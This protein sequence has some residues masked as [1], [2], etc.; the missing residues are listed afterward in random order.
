MNSAVCNAPC[1]I[2]DSG[3]FY[4]VLCVGDHGHTNDHSYITN[5]FHTGSG[6]IINWQ[7]GFEI[8]EDLG[9]SYTPSMAQRCGEW[10]HIEP[11][12]VLKPSVDFQT[13]FVGSKILTLIGTN[14]LSSFCCEKELSHKDPHTRSGVSLGTKS[15][16]EW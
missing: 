4:F 13:I 12:I 9:Q 16:I 5:D 2:N 10:L 8:E 1:I 15:K 7:Y 6:V 11:L 14:T 3:R